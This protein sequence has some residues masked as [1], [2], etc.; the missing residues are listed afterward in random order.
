MKF[1]TAAENLLCTAPITGNSIFKSIFASTWSGATVQAWNYT[2]KAG[3]SVEN[4]NYFWVLG[5]SNYTG[6]IDEDDLK[7]A[8]SLWDFIGVI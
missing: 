4:E 7:Y 2:I 1:D 6:L 8:E 3:E 5:D